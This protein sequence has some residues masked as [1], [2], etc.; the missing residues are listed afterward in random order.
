[1]EQSEL[2]LLEIV[3]LASIAA[4]FALRLYSV[5]G[6]RTGH[7]PDPAAKPAPARRAGEPA[8]PQLRAAFTG[9]AAAGMEAIRTADGAFEPA[10]FVEG[11]SK[12]YD[13]V[14]EAFAAGDKNTLR[15][16]LAD[17]VFT[18]YET[19]IDAREAAGRR[20]MSDLIK[21]D[22]AEI[23]AAELA[24]RVARVTVRFVAELASAVTD[25][26]GKVIEG[27][28]SQIRRV[29]ELWTFERDVDAGDPNWTLARVAPV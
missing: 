26:D 13:L 1:M 12:A 22:R 24:D 27:D 20:Q 25:A 11:A 21:I 28:P 4:F 16:L 23:E 10:P 6:K 19:A 29:E 17:N 3:L 9:P 14:I 2:V 7:E 15:K 5:L 8:P 18:R